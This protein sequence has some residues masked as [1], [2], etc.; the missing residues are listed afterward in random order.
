MAGSAA[1]PAV[2]R[3]ELGRTGPVGQPRPGADAPADGFGRDDAREAPRELL[4]LAARAALRRKG[5]EHLLPKAR[6][7]RN[8][9]ACDHGRTGV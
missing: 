8:L 5:G 1:A 6:P 4:H 2:D 3:H 7:R 9:C